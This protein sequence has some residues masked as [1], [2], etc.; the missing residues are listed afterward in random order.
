MTTDA[1]RDASQA[2]ADELAEGNVVS[3]DGLLLNDVTGEITAMPDGAGDRMEYLALKKLQAKRNIEGWQQAIALYDQAVDRL[4]TQA[5]VKSVKTPYGTLSWQQQTRESASAERLR[6][7]IS[8]MEP[9]LADEL[10]L[11]RTLAK[12]LDAKSVRLSA[13]LK[14]DEK[15]LLIERKDTKAYIRLD[16]PRTAAPDIKE[17][18]AQ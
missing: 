6:Q 16:P 17:E 14:D 11:W 13:L 18:V 8:Q 5:G 3:L 9:P 7:F 2:L 15:E 12:T 10:T 1:V 4:L